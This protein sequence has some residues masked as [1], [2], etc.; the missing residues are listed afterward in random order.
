MKILNELRLQFEDG[1]WALDPE[2]A[3][4]DMVLG[5]H[6]EYYEWVAEEIVS[7]NKDNDLGRGDT[8]T[9][10][11]VVRAAIFKELK[12]LR[13][14]GTGVRT[15]R[16][17]DL[18]GVHQAGDERAILVRDVLQIHIENIGGFLDETHGGD[19][20]AWLWRKDWKTELGFGS[21]RRSWRAISTT[22][23][24]TRWYGIA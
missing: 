14:S 10:E 22:R 13:R 20:L 21:T 19:Q 11:Q 23:R 8:P 18:P 9:V 17:A 5:L 6:P 3:L 15:I 4:I 7:G 12:Q 24:T 2:L 16:F 1:L